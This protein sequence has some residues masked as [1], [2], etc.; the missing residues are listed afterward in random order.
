MTPYHFP[1]RQITTFLPKEL[2]CCKGIL[3]FHNFTLFQQTFH[4]HGKPWD[5]YECQ[6]QKM[7]CEVGPGDMCQ[8][9]GADNSCS[10]CNAG[11]RLMASGSCEAFPCQTGDDDGCSSCVRQR[12]RSRVNHCGSCNAGYQLSKRGSCEAFVCT[13]GNGDA[14]RSCPRVSKRKMDNECSACNPGFQ[15]VGA[16][17]VP[18][19]CA[20]SI[21]AWPLKLVC[22]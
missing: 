2:E 4:F 17:C 14:C 12:E 6:G 3:E 13:T 15:L 9:C 18:F 16:K 21:G 22:F 1:S 19:T 20:V 11:Y 7:T 10:S 8:K 5:P